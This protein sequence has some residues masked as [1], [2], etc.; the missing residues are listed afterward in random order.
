MMNPH[1]RSVRHVLR[2]GH[3]SIKPGKLSVGVSCVPTLLS[4][5]GQRVGRCVL[6]FSLGCVEKEY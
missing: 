5:K 4:E 6:L 3:T 1:V 2:L